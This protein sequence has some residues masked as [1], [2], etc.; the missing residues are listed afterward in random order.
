MNSPAPTSSA[1]AP[2][3]HTERLVPR[4]FVEADLDAHA[5]MCADAEVM[6]HIG[7]GGPVARRSIALAQRLG[8]W[9]EETIEFMGA[10][11]QVWRHPDAA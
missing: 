7:A 3:L 11:A 6:R 9:H 10:T 5:A 2:T 4:P 1:T 8:A